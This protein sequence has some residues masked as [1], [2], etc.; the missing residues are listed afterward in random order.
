MYWVAVPSPGDL[1]N[2]GMEPALEGDS[3]PAEPPGKPSLPQGLH[4]KVGTLL[5]V[6]PQPG[7]S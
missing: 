5:K 1:P 4:L 3:L 6:H 2:P 7:F